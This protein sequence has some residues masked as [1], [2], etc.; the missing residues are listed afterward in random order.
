MYLKKWFNFKYL[1]QNFKK[2]KSLLLFLLCGIPF[3]NLW[4]VGINLLSGVYIIDFTSVSGVSSIIA[5]ILPV[6]L[7]FSLFGFVFKKN[8]VD[9]I[10]SM[11]ISRRQ[12]F[13]S[14]I[15]GGIMFIFIIILLNTIGFILLSLFTKLFIPAGVIIDYFVY[16]LITYIF[17]FIVSSLAISLSGNIMGTIVVI[18]LIIFLYPC[19]TI[20]NNN[21]QSNF[22]DAYLICENEDCLPN[23]SYCNNNECLTNLENGKYYYS[24]GTKLN[25][26][27]TTPLNYF[28]DRYNLNSIIK[29]LILSVI[30]LVI[31][32]YLFK[33]RKM[34]NSEIS[35]KNKY[36]YKVIKILA[37]I[38]ITYL[39]Y[40]FYTSSS[41][42]LLIGIILCFAY[43]FIYDLIIKKE[44][45]NVLKT[46]CE[47]I[48]VSAIFIG[49]YYILEMIYSSNK[50]LI[51]IPDEVVVSYY[52]QNLEYDYEII[53]ND[54]SL[55]NELIKTKDVS[56]W[57]GNYTV[58]FENKYYLSGGLSDELVEKLDNYVKEK[59][60]LANYTTDNIL[61]ITS[62][63]NPGLV[64]PNTTK[65][66]NMIVTY[67]QDY[68]KTENRVNNYI[69]IY[70][71]EDHQIKS[72]SIDI[73]KNLEILNY[74]KNFYNDSFLKNFGDTIGGDETIL[75]ENFST[76]VNANKKSFLKFLQEHKYDE[77]T[78]NIIILYSGLERF[79]INQSVL[80][81]F[82]MEYDVDVTNNI[83]YKE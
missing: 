77:L 28:N 43:Y 35:F 40:L 59:N 9:F 44:I 38:P 83:S 50:N 67:L 82:L 18:L 45:T 13:A 1:Y 60:L 80:E 21:I 36:L 54:K 41:A 8:N 4:L 37:Y 16:W 68:E 52:D 63:I 27:F 64:I 39:A 74:V 6:I 79:I 12:I 25:T 17:I 81:N 46:L 61:H 10:M 69:T 71:Y 3:I 55:I 51:N 19:F 47:M 58:Y 5:F 24:I 20:I 49:G 7:A 14:N 62:S 76:F 29:T 56:S 48:I 72:I 42:L 31:A 30:Y 34:E 22:Q 32:Y 78:E 33:Y 75:G 57:N 15:L 2:S 53:V 26:T 11:P 66:K 65:L 70:K 23:S 73:L